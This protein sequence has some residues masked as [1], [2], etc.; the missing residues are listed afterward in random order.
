MRLVRDQG[1]HEAHNFQ[2]PHCTRPAPSPTAVDVFARRTERVT[3]NGLGIRSQLPFVL[4]G[5]QGTESVVPGC[6]EMRASWTGRCY[7]N[8]AFWRDSLTMSGPD[9]IGRGGR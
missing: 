1:D 3:I 7:S 4:A 6:S 2:F 9:G 8:A 5:D